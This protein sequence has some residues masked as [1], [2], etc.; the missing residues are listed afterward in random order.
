M[1]QKS[2]LGEVM[3]DVG[4]ATVD[5]VGHDKRG[6]WEQVEVS[7]MVRMSVCP[8]HVINILYLK[9]KLSQAY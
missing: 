5:V 7:N 3:G 6:L 2:D 9:P 8:N 4:V 1:V